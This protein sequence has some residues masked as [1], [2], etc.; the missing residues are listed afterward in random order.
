MSFVKR[1]LT[2]LPLDELIGAPLTACAKSQQLL[3]QTTIDFIREVGMDVSGNG[4]ATLRTISFSYSVV[5]NG[6]ETNKTITV[7]L[8]TIV[9]IPSLSIQTCDIN[10][11]MNVSQTRTTEAQAS[12]EASYKAWYSPVSVSFK[13]SVSSSSNKS[14]SA[15]YVVNVSAADNGPPDGLAKILTMLETAIS[16]KN[17]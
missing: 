16:E 6:A 12:V 13:G 8:L 3:A 7:P 10:F 17:E 4:Q 14:A 9:N 15:K 1:S 2:N 11:E 5:D